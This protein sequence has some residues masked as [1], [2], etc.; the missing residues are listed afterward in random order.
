MGKL[1]NLSSFLALATFA[2]A[3][4]KLLKGEICQVLSS[5]T[6]MFDKLLPCGEYW[7]EAVDMACLTD[8]E[9]LRAL[10]EVPQWTLVKDAQL[11]DS[12][13]RTFVFDDF[14]AAFFFM[15]QSA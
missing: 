8:Q 1:S 9:T 10:K 14:Q 7:A 2:Q 3:E 15:T 4:Y 5:P 11:G 12:I 6:A 13:K